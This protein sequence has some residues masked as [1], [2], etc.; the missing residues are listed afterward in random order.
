M[1]HA[2]VPARDVPRKKPSWLK[3]IGGVAITVG[4]LL[5]KLKGVLL[6]TLTK[7]KWLFV[8]PFEGF[9]LA[10]LM[11]TAGSMVLTI[12][13]YILK[14]GWWQ[15]AIGFVLITLIHE[16][17]HALVMRRKGLR[18]SAMLFIPF[19]GGAVTPKDEPRTAYDDAQIGFA[20]PI[21]GT[22]ASLIALVIFDITADELYLLVA[23]AGFGINLLNLLPVGVLDGG[24]ISAAITKWMWVIGGLIMLW[25]MVRWRSPLLLLILVLAAWQIYLAVTQVRDDVYYAITAAQRTTVAVLYFSLV[26][27]LGY[28]TYATH[29]YLLFLQG[30]EQ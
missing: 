2:A 5:L 1:E 24:K 25:M 6:L 23:F 22:I 12:V 14:T 8:N 4:L 21:F 27:F 18:V 11:V 15:F 20:G 10:S 7:F 30:G 16:V 17:G 29:N 19:I 28:M 3:L 13:A 26:I 9:S